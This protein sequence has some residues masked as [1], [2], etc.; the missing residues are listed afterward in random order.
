MA[1]KTKDSPVTGGTKKAGILNRFDN[2]WLN[3]K[4]LS[5]AGHH[6]L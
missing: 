5:G 4:F 3:W 6:R 1:E 2:P